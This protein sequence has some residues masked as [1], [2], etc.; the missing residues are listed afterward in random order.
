M[1][2]VPV[3]MNEGTCLLCHGEIKDVAALAADFDGHAFLDRHCNAADSIG[4][5][6]LGNYV[7][8]ALCLA[9][10]CCGHL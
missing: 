6:R 1:G 5:T 7:K 3:L 4:Q 10:T 9:S 8:C 2:S